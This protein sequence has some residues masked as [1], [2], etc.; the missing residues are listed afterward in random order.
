MYIFNNI[1]YYKILQRVLKIQKVKTKK[2]YPV[3]KW[4]FIWWWIWQY[5]DWKWRWQWWDIPNLDKPVY[6]GAPIT[7]G[8]SALA[9]LTVATRFKIAGVLLS[10]LL[11]LIELHC[12]RPNHCIKSLYKLKKIFANSYSLTVKHFYFFFFLWDLFKK[13]G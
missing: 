12:I 8:E 1:I 9:I 4:K 2:V 6:P 10:C 11:S 5:R 13:I 7:I 3:M